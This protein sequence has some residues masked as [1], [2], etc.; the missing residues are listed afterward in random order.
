M[1]IRRIYVVSSLIGLL[2]ATALRASDDQG[3]L[4]VVKLSPS[5]R[6]ISHDESA[7]QQIPCRELG[8]VVAKDEGERHLL[9]KRKKTCLEQ[10]RAFAPRSFQP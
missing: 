1:T 5:V 7:F 2:F 8:S 10:F 9:N 3:E 4:P 6:D